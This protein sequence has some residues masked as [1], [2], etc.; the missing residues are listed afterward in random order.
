MFTVASLMIRLSR[1][2]SLQPAH[3]D[4]QG[5]CCIARRFQLLVAA[6]SW[7]VLTTELYSQTAKISVPQTATMFCVFEVQIF[8]RMLYGKYYYFLTY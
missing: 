3:P 8:F 4:G 6:H 2:R 5:E 1:R 7:V